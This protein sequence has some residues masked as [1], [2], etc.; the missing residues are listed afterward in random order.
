MTQS[1]PLVF[2]AALN[3]LLAVAIGAFG[4]HAIQDPQAQEWIRTATLFQLPH[5]AAAIAVL[6]WR[7]DARLVPW[8]LLAG[9]LLFAG[10]LQALG[11]GAPRALAMLAPV[12]GSLMMLGWAALAVSALRGGAGGGTGKG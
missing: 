3:G 10:S 2:L 1:R 8:L 12:G 9:S 4:A 7:P 5:A 6:A 11:L